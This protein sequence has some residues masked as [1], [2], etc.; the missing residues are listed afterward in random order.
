MY[1]GKQ[2]FSFGFPEKLTGGVFFCVQGLQSWMEIKFFCGRLGSLFMAKS[3]YSRK[4][5]DA[6]SLI[7]LSVL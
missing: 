6:L 5:V 4:E 7:H 3:P 2:E 1:Y